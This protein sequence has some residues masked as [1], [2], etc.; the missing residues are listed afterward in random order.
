MCEVSKQ[1][2]SAAEKLDLKWGDEGKQREKHLV[3]TVVVPGQKLD[4]AGGANFL[5]NISL[6]NVLTLLFLHIYLY[7]YYYKINTI[8]FIL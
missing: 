1:Q 2:S 3:K 7:S 6:Q 5:P 8:V 4:S